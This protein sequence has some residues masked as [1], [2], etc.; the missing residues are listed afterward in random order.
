MK[1]Y[2]LWIVLVAFLIFIV[3]SI[4]GCLDPV[5]APAINGMDISVFDTARIIAPQ[6]YQTTLDYLVRASNPD[7]EYENVYTLISA[8]NSTARLL[9]NSGFW[10]VDVIGF[11]VGMAPKEEDWYFWDSQSSDFSAIPVSSSWK[12]EYIVVVGRGQD[13]AESDDIFVPVDSIIPVHVGFTG[14]TYGLNYGSLGYTVHLPDLNVANGDSATL[15][16][17]RQEETA[18]TDYDLLVTA[19]NDTDTFRN[20]YD[21]DNATATGRISNLHAGF[22]DVQVYVV[23]NVLPS[24]DI[25]YVKKTDIAHIYQNVPSDFEWIFALSEMTSYP[26]GELSVS[27]VDPAADLITEDVLVLYKDNSNRPLEA[28]LTGELHLRKDWKDDFTYMQIRVDDDDTDDSFFIDFRFD[29]VAGTIHLNSIDFKLGSSYLTIYIVD[30]NGIPW[31]DT[32]LIQTVNGPGLFR[33]YSINR[34]ESLNATSPDFFKQAMAYIDTHGVEGDYWYITLLN[35][36]TVDTT[37]LLG[38]KPLVLSIAGYSNTPDR[39]GGPVITLSQTGASL[40]TLDPDNARTLS[41]T[42]GGCL[43]LEGLD[44]NAFP[45]INVLDSSSLTLSGKL[46]LINNGGTGIS[47]EDN[48]RVNMIGDVS[49]H[50]SFALNGAGVYIGPNGNFIMEKGRIGRNRAAN[51]GGGVF[52][53][54]DAGSFAKTGGIIY[55]SD[56]DSNLNEAPKGAAFYSDPDRARNRTIT[57]QEPLKFLNGEWQIWSAD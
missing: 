40:F 31:T 27:Y 16:I 6:G 36:E 12:N 57:T 55:G 20:T 21:I 42:L 50:G 48:G 45:L 22:Y 30:S 53:A 17:K 24:G 7:G 39:G 10:R 44:A 47:V 32:C 5:R 56:D 33:N 11:K 13:S 28:G 25:R 23:K 3:F 38:G 14:Y 9:V 1:K 4:Y 43:K 41:L 19:N 34:I 51:S 29:P 52:L 15:S 54:T 18:Y 26:G 37:Y 2:L 46:E 8:G 35:S 49:I